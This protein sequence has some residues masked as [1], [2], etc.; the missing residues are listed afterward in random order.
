MKEQRYTVPL[1]AIDRF[2]S[3]KTRLQRVAAWWVRKLSM[4]APYTPT[5][6]KVEVKTVRLGEK[7]EEDISRMVLYF[8]GTDRKLDPQRDLVI[9][10]GNEEWARFMRG[11]AKYLVSDMS[12]ARA[13][14]DEYRGMRVVLVSYLSGPLVIRR[15]DLDL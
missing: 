5:E 15:R 11:K 2:M 3:P 10:W 6:E 9:L 1:P 4:V 13:S 7:A 14:G 8:M 12:F